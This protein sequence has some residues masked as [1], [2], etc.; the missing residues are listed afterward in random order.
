MV[1]YDYCQRPNV[2]NDKLAITNT[3]EAASYPLNFLCVT[4]RDF[5]ATKYLRQS[6]ASSPQG[7]RVLGV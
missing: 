4:V 1:Y 3:R 5:V 6:A 2:R 7:G